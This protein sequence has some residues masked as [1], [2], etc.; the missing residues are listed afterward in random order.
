MAKQSTAVAV[1]EPE[2]STELEVSPEQA[3][4]EAQ[5]AAQ[6]TD[7]IDSS[8]IQIP[9]LKVGQPLTQEVADGDARP[10]EFINALTREGLGDEIDFVVS[11]YQKGRFFHGDRANNRRARKAYGV[12]NVPWQDDPFY[13]QPFTEHPDAEEQYAK[14]VNNKEIE[15]GKGPS[16][17]T[18]FDFTGFV[19]PEDP[20]EE[21]I[22]VCLSLMRTNRRAAQK[23]VTILQA[24]L[25]GKYWD[26]VFHLTTER[27]ANDKGNYYTVNVK[28]GR[29]TTP[30]ERQRAL[31]LALILRQRADSVQIVGEDDESA[32]KA[33]PDAAGGM[34]V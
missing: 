17:S 26:S 16:I 4:L 25:R 23:W 13:G 3:E 32:P 1:P 20:D 24:V 22:P 14:R 19:V 29:K 5:L 30:A 6:N 31:Q 10:G 15:W 7:E 34:G 27:T 8:D 9:L 18:T 33:E 2:E 12:K 28:Q 11:G 21:P